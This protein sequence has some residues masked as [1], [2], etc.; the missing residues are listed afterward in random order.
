MAYR[1]VER[2]FATRTNEDTTTTQAVYA[3]LGGLRHPFTPSVSGATLLSSESRSP[4][5]PLSERIDPNSVLGLPTKRHSCK[6]GRRSRRLGRALS[7]LPA[8]YT[9]N[10]R[11]RQLAL[12]ASGGRSVIPLPDSSTRRDDNESSRWGCCRSATGGNGYHRDD[13]ALLPLG[14]EHSFAARTTASLFSPE[15]LKGA[16]LRRACLHCEEV[17]SRRIIPRTSTSTLST[18]IDTGNAKHSRGNSV[19][20]ESDVWS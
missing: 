3:R 5:L 16:V 12:S 19:C 13:V 1:P 8:F 20:G 18:V 11:R 4:R 9:S 10:S 14:D 17:R 2:T 7:S 6:Q 15:T